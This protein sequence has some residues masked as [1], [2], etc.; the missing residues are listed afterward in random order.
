MQ[1]QKAETAYPLA[2]QLLNFGFAEQIRPID[3]TVDFAIIHITL[4]VFDH[5]FMEKH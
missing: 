5:D 4:N 3:N 1:S 2:K